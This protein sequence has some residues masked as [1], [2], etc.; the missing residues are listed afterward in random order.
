MTRALGSATALLVTILITGAWPAVAGGNAGGTVHLTWDSDGQIA[1][2]AV[3][4]A[5]VFPLFLRIEGAPDIRQLAINLKWMPFDSLGQ[6]YKVVPAAEDSSCGWAV[7]EPPAGGFEGDST[8]TWSIR[9]PA[10]AQKSCVVYWVSMATCDSVPPGKFY[11]GDARVKDSAGFVDTLLNVG[12]TKLLGGPRPDSISQAPQF[13]LD[14]PGGAGEL[15]LTATPNPGRSLILV[16]FDLPSAMP[17]SLGIFDV[18]GRLVRRAD[19]VPTAG[20]SGAYAWDLRDGAGQR[21]R[22]GVYFARLSTS[23]GSRA[24]PLAVLR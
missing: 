13:N 8:Y 1:T 4:K 10:G 2:E 11:V 23:A 7:E 3:P 9:F 14:H 12:D 20:G 16:R 6:C 24:V 22:V 19:V 17:F 15:I 21:V 5:T 18:S